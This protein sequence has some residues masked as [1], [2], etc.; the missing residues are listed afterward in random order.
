M[1]HS[2]RILELLMDREMTVCR[3][4][5]GSELNHSDAYRVSCS[6]H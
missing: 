4:P 5:G 3:G 6:S 2:I 1:Q